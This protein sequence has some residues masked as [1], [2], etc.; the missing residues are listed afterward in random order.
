MVPF[1]L[2]QKKTTKHIFRLFTLKLLQRETGSKILSFT[3]NWES[4]CIIWVPFVMPSFSWKGKRA[5]YFVQPH[6]NAT[7]LL[8]SQ[9][10]HPHFLSL[11]NGCFLELHFV[12]CTKYITKFLSSILRNL[13][14][15]PYSPNII[16]ITARTV[17]LKSKLFLPLRLCMHSWLSYH[18]YLRHMP[19]SPIYIFHLYTLVQ[20]HT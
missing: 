8:K 7:L 14:A 9:H 19:V 12:H 10:E 15:F 4:V 6:C 11:S 1:T 2:C 5:V 3:L 18:I 13:P 20:R 17:L 16:L